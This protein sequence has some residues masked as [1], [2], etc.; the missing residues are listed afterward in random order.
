MF[1]DD[2]AIE[3][4]LQDVCLVATSVS[5]TVQSAQRF[6]DVLANWV[7]RSAKRSVVTTRQQRPARG[8]TFVAF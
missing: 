6:S 7:R 5:W 2:D 8:T 4:L 3:D 1:H